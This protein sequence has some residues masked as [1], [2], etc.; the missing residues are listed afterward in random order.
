MNTQI[1]ESKN[2]RELTKLFDERTLFGKAEVVEQSKCTYGQPIKCIAKY[3]H[4]YI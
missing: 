4:L 1:E 3:G 2:E